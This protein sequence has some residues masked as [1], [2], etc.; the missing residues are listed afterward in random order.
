MRSSVAAIAGLTLCLPRLL[1]LLVGAG[2]DTVHVF[3]TISEGIKLPA[4]PFV[5]DISVMS[6]CAE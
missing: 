4:Q 5:R 3:S 6:C 1:V 2:I